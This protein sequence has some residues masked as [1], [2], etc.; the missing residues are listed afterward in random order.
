MKNL[1][2]DLSQSSRCPQCL[3]KMHKL[4]LKLSFLENEKRMGWNITHSCSAPYGLASGL[5]YIAS[6][7]K[8]EAGVIHSVY[9]LM[10]MIKSYRAA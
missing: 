8:T 7:K 9:V 10:S 6:L 1:A 3:E 5:G 2:F 4:L